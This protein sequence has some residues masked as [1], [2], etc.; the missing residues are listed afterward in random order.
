MEKQKGLGKTDSKLSGP[1]PDESGLTIGSTVE[2]IAEIPPG[3]IR[4]RAGEPY[5]S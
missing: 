3:G 5:K 2:A 1:S 4:V